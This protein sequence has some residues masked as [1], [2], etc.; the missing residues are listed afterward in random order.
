MTNLSGKDD[1]HSGVGTVWRTVA[2]GVGFL[3]A[4]GALMFL[5]GGIGWGKGWLFLGVFACMAVVGSVYLWRANREI[6]FARSKIHAGTKSWDK[7]LLALIL[8]GFFAIFPVAG[9][10][11]RFAGASVPVWLE[12]T[13][14]N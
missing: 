3:L 5:P 12:L 14:T 10:D 8:G 11:E 13:R 2:A 9:L 6:F 4:I 1:L 7:P